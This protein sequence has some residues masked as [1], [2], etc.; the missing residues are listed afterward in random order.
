MTETDTDPAT[1]GVRQPDSRCVRLLPTS[2]LHQTGATAAP[3]STRIESPPASHTRSSTIRASCQSTSRPGRPPRA[4]RYTLGPPRDPP[5]PSHFRNAPCRSRCH[6]LF[7]SPL[8]LG[9]CSLRP[10]LLDVVPES[11]PRHFR[12]TSCPSVWRLQCLCPQLASSHL[13]IP[14]QGLA[15]DWQ[16]NSGCGF[17]LPFP[18]SWR[19]SNVSFWVALDFF[20]TSSH[21]SARAS[22]QAA[23][24]TPRRCRHVRL[25][26]VKIGLAVYPAVN[27]WSSRTLYV[28]PQ[29]L[30]PADRPNGRRRPP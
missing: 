19:C 11:P 24:K 12:T 7:P 5:P 18:V 26:P 17:S 13:L 2:S 10:P 29:A 14:R 20:L 30:H 15:R 25:T 1:L 3:T 22:R 16:W 28:P 4:Q 27:S 21:P 8:P 6:I 9:S 23:R